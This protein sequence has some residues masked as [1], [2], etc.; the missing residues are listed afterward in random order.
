MGI[1]WLRFFRSLTILSGIGIAF[2]CISVAQGPPENSSWLTPGKLTNV[3]LH[4]PS[5]MP[6]VANQI[7]HQAGLPTHQEFSIQW[8][9]LPGVASSVVK[10]QDVQNIPISPNFV[11][12]SRKHSLDGGTRT[13]APMLVNDELVVAAATP[14]GEIRGLLI[15]WDPR[16]SFTEDVAR[17]K[18]TD[19]VQPNVTFT[20]SIPD[21]AQIK[22]IVFLQPVS[23]PGGGAILN[24]IGEIPLSDNRITREP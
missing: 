16:A 4:L 5:D 6:T 11:I 2:I 18:K 23:A 24:F 17:G 22:K 7:G 3:G 13:R 12:L 20:L 9:S 10:K 15:I 19:L 8:N 1:V 14:G 21:D